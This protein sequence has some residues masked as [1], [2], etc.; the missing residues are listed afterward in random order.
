MIEESLIKSNFIGRDGFR[1]WIGQ[2]PPESNHS[3]QING[4]GWGNRFKV[5]IMGYHPYNTVELPNEDLPWAQVLLSPTDGT[6]AGNQATSVKLSPGDVVFGFFLDGDSA[7]VPVIT[8]CFGRTSQV[9]SNDYVGPFMPFTGYT[10]KIKNDGSYILN[11]QTNEQNAKSQKSPRSVSP[12]QATQIGPNERSAYNGIGDVI[13]AASPSNTNTINKITTE[14]ENFANKI[15]TFTRGVSGT[16]QSINAEIGK[17]TAKIQK[18]ASGL[19]NGM[20][21]SLYEALAPILNAGLKLLY[22]TVYAIVFAATRSTTAAHLAGVAA[23]N[24]MV[25]PVKILQDQLPCV[26][27][28]VLDAIGNTIRGLLNSVAENVSNFVTCVGDQFVGALLN[29]IIGG[30]EQLLAPALNGVEKILM[31]FNLISFLRS[32]IEGL[33]SPGVKSSCNEVAP[34]YNSA[35]NKW[36]IGKGAKESPGVPLETILATAN[37]AIAIAD[38]VSN[39]ES[40]ES[41][42]GS[43]DFLNPNFSI[44]GFT[45]VLSDCYGGPRLNCGG[46]K[47]NIFG[48]TGSGAS[49]KAILG[50]IVGEGRYATGSII[51]L[52]VI[53]GGSGYD[54]PPFVEIVDDCNNGYG[55]I[56][57]AIVDYDEESPT[58]KQ[59]IGIYV[60]SEGENY[61]ISDSEEN[62]ESQPP[63]VIG[64]ILIVDSGTDY[65]NNDKVIDSNGIEYNIEVGENGE[66]IKVFPINSELN[67]VNE[68]V[69]LPDFNISSQTGKGALLTAKLKPKPKYQGEIKQQIDC[70][71]K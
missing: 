67:N 43:F 44:Q 32:N 36:V 24:A 53:N 9:P 23:Q 69:D 5:R 38:L 49:A 6:G 15:Q 62:L 28:F 25:L 45:S 47:V 42:V 4:G 13:N 2:I 54:Y 26:A 18:I 30:I 35:T 66:I 59:V 48:S 65:T 46:V 70:I 68:V 64:D 22:R 11:D 56:G 71:S 40:L 41:I 7:Q 52:D 37:E 21:N 8:G 51:G 16:I 58:Y 33:L 19:I 10:S 3:T 31:G 39:P 17:I 61:P 1:W 14:V 34:N 57:R 12:Q 50:S 29:Y 27:N 20:I 63:Y 55:A 60:V